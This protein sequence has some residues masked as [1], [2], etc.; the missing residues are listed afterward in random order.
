MSNLS[1]F[2]EIAKQSG[3][4]LLDALN[5]GNNHYQMIQIDEI[6]GKGIFV[7]RASDKKGNEIFN[8][9][10][11]FGETPKGLSVCWRNLSIIK[12]DIQDF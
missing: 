3:Y 10:N 11:E 2:Y 9:L 1:M 8:I 6:I 4:K 5:D 12:K 7:F